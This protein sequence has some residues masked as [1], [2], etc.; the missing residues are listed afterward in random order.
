MAVAHS[1]RDDPLLRARRL[2]Q[3]GH[4]CT[5]ALTLPMPNGS[6]LP[7]SSTIVITTVTAVVPGRTIAPSLTAFFGT[8]ILAPPGPTRLNVTAPGRPSTTASIVG[9][10]TAPGPRS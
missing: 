6:A 4:P 3:G 8:C 9:A 10:R 1:P 7:T 5:T 2:P